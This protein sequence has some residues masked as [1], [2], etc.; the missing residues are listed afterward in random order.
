MYPESSKILLGNYISIRLGVKHASQLL[1]GG[2]SIEAGTIGR[3][4]VQGIAA[5]ETR[6][7]QIALELR[8]SHEENPRT[9]AKDVLSNH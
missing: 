9:C 2:H 4:Q 1:M 5:N 7:G 6:N 8:W 3:H